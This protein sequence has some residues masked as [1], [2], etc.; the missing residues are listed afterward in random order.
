MKRP[1]ENRCRSQASCAV[2]IGLRGKAIATAVPNFIFV[3]CSA[4][5][6]SGRN[7]SC[8]ASGVTTES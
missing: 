3:V 2:T 4:T 1:P 6:I 8:P 7:G 5:V